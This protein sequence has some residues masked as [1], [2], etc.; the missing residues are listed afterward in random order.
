[1]KKILLFGLV[2][3]LFSCSG[4]KSKQESVSGKQVKKDGVCDILLEATVNEMSAPAELRTWVKNMK[5]HSVLPLELTDSSMLGECRIAG[6]VDDKIVLYDSEAIYS[7]NAQTGN[8]LFPISRKGDGPEEYVYILDLAISPADT[9]VYVFDGNKKKIN[10]YSLHSGEFMRSIKNDSIVSLEILGRD[11]WLTYNSPVKPYHYDICMHNLKM[12]NSRGVSVRKE[13]IEVNKGY[14]TMN[15]FIKSNDS[16][17]YYESDTLF[18]IHETGR[19]SPIVYIDK[20]TLDLPIEVATDYKRKQERMNY[21]WGERLRFNDRYCFLSFYHKN[22]AYFDVWDLKNST[23]LYRNVATNISSDLG[24]EVE[25]E[26]KTIYVWPTFVKDNFFYCVLDEV[27][28]EKLTGKT[29]DNPYILKLYI[30][31]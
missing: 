27:A 14:V 26:G 4:S 18:Q 22:R 2:A 17:F 15:D 13:A 28:V 25:I 3:L 31:E 21:I 9:A 6:E 16:V 5:V 24:V 1:M 7:F 30:E 23:L 29:G 19:I 12:G 20:G 8:F 11:N 10:I